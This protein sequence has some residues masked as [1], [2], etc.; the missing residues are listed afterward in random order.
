MLKLTRLHLS[1]ALLLALSLPLASLSAQ[2][3][4]ARP[5]RLKVQIIS[6]RPHDP[7]AFTQGLLIHDGFFYESTG[8]YGSSTLRKVDMRTGEVLQQVVL[9]PEFFAEGLALV[10]NRLIQLTWREQV[11][12]VYDLE[13]FQQL[14]TINYLGEGWGLCYDAESE[15]L[16]M[17]D[18]SHILTV[19]DP[20]TF[21][22]IRRLEIWLDDVPMRNLNELECAGDSIYANIWFSDQI[23]R[24]DKH[25]G[26]VTAIIEA[27]NLLTPEERAAA[28]GSAVLN[29]IAYEPESERFFLTGKLWLWLFEVEFVP[30]LPETYRTPTPLAP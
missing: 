6:I 20:Q 18:G 25:S 23:L 4:P 8:L 29:G 7:F 1:L 9:P 26:R 11:A 2:E 15:S 27:A 5:E 3:P 14:Q 10:E 21:E 28:G 13:T 30:E 17:S 22:V 16:Y 12:F 19:R 24:I